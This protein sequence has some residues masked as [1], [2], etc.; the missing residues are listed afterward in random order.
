MLKDEFIKMQEQ[1]L[2]TSTDS[3]AKGM[4]EC[5]KEILKDYPSTLDIDPSLNCKDCFSKLREKARNEA[6]NGMYYFSLS[7][8]TKFVL[9]YLKIGQMKTDRQ[10]KRL[11]DF[12]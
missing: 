4:L 11:E 3:G 10:I 5:F 12:F 2:V 6:K 7:A 8:T 1:D 9:N